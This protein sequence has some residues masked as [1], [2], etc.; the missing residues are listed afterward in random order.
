MEHIVQLA[1]GG[2]LRAATR[3]CLTVW[4]CARGTGAAC[5]I[6]SLLQAAA[7]SIFS[8]P[9]LPWVERGRERE[10]G[11]G[12]GW[13][14]VVSSRRV[15]S[16][17]VQTQWWGAA[18]TWWKGQF[19]RSKELSPSRTYLFA[20]ASHL[21]SLLLFQVLRAQYSAKAGALKYVL[22][23]DPQSNWMIM[24][25]SVEEIVQIRCVDPTSCQSFCLFCFVCSTCSPPTL[26]V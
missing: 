12:W 16:Q 24:K 23:K 17:C 6:S 7:G 11:K 4:W 8:P 10:G 13:G 18:A 14:G 20:P 21:C 15:E 22:F 2:Q 3:V 1:R 5:R 9:Q 26:F 19:L 25:L